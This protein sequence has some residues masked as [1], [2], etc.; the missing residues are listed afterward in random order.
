MAGVRNIPRAMSAPGFM[1]IYSLISLALTVHFIVLWARFSLL[2]VTGRRNKKAGAGQPVSC[3]SVFVVEELLIHDLP[4]LIRHDQHDRSRAFFIVHNGGHV[5]FIAFIRQL[6][7][8]VFF[9]R[10]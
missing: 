4:A 10:F 5:T 9:N 6:F 3:L 8:V 2:P 1:T 7:A